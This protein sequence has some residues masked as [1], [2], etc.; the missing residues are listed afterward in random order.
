[1][2]RDVSLLSPG[3]FLCFDLEKKS[4]EINSYWDFHFN[5]SRKNSSISDLEQELDFLFSRSVNRQLVADVN[6]G[7]YLSGG[8]DSG[9]ITAVAS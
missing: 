2:F 4:I 8:I 9:A 3:N 1:M 7:A 5:E 6:V